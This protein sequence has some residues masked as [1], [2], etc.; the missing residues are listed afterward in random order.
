MSEL[1]AWWQTPGLAV[2]YIRCS[3]LIELV[4]R[5]SADGVRSGSIMDYSPGEETRRKT[6]S[7]IH[8][9]LFFDSNQ[10]A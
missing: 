5:V 3:G 8:F 7:Q 2:T 9:C 1:L 4:Y 6:A 10:V